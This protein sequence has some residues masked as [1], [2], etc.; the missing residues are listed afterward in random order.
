MDEERGP[1]AA[2]LAA[3][4]QG[5]EATLGPNRV[6]FAGVSGQ[7]VFLTWSSGQM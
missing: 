3:W 6:A 5:S 1:E 2:C 4:I 7:V